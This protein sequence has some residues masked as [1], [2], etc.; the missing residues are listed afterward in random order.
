MEQDW[1]VEIGVFPESRVRALGFDP[2]QLT[3]EEQTELLELHAVCP[4]E[5][6]ETGVEEAEVW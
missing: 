6:H 1:P 3:R 5:S 4:D 2:S